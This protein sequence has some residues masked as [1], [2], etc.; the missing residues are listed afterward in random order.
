MSKELISRISYWFYLILGISINSYQGYKYFTD[1]LDFN[2]GEVLIFALAITLT[3]KPN[4]IPDLLKTVVN[5]FS[6]NDKC[7]HDA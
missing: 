4:L 7:K 3:I 6:N 5:K 1:K 2:Y